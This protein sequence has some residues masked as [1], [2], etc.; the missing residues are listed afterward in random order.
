[1][2]ISPLWLRVPWMIAVNL[3]FSFR[4][5]SISWLKRSGCKVSVTRREAA[6]IDGGRKG[7]D[8]NNKWMKEENAGLFVSR[9]AVSFS[10]T[11]FPSHYIRVA[12]GRAEPATRSATVPS[13]PSSIGSCS[14]RRAPACGAYGTSERMSETNR[15][16]G[17]VNE[18]VR[19]GVTTEPREPETEG[20]VS[21]DSLRGLHSSL[22]PHPVSREVRA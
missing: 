7:R 22:N 10:L 1:M 6:E 4:T 20:R 11:T 2:M 9:G 13:V 18:A 19:S 21:R 3:S 5:P 15:G 17:E 16:A 8:T 12:D 14:A